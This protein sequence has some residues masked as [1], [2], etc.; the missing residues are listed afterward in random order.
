MKAAQLGWKAVLLGAATTFV[1]LVAGSS[2]VAQRWNG[3]L[4]ED[5]AH[6]ARAPTPVELTPGVQAAFRRESYV[7]GSTAS[8]R[9][10]RTVR[11]VTMQVFRVG[12][13]R[14]MPCGH[15]EMV[16]IPETEALP[17]G[18]LRQG[19]LVTI[20]VG[21]HWPSGLFFVRLSSARMVGF[22]PFVVRP[23][24]LGEHP[25]A[26]VLPTLTWQA[27]NLR[28]DDGNGVGNSW[29]AAWRIHTVRL[30]R[31]Y[32]NRGVPF[33][34]NRY[35]LPFLRWLDLEGKQVDVLSDADLDAVGSGRRLADAYTL[36]IFPG[37][38]E[39]VTTHEYDV[40]EQY[41][42]LGGHLMFLS[43]NNFFWKVIKRGNI[44]K[45]TK[46][47]R[48]L[49]RPEAAMV[50]VEYRASDGGQHRGP[51]IVRNAPAGAWI[52]QG[53]NLPVGTAFASGGIE[54]DKIASES[55]RRIQVL[56]AIPD[57]FGPGLTAQMTYYEEPCDAQ[58]FAAG[59]FRL[60]TLPLQ[61]EITRLLENLWNH[62][63]PPGD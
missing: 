40:V 38:H 29:Y 48:D 35:D 58:V 6:E 44:I 12:P 61:P 43:A 34:F 31:P 57:L 25:V 39:Y 33:N 26:V 3:E 28:D 36:V 7:P 21:D 55:P 51:W 15:N 13:E 16:G 60:V 63:A 59:A 41:R 5:E 18:T 24:S 42:K 20:R 8:F 52:F 46:M 47:W 54:I 1:L 62:M 37:H 23:R 22:A 53:C 17:L 32:L 49:G 9:I 10:F 50:G 11:S 19:R 4:S 27:Y 30:A 45:R 56:A 14:T 2:P